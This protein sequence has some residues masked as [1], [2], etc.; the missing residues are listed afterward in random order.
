[1]PITVLRE[2]VKEVTDLSTKKDLI[3]SN[4]GHLLA[5]Y[6]DRYAAK[7]PYKVDMIPE[8]GTS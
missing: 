3:I 7:L 4:D 2:S 6:G 1:M 5:W 8:T